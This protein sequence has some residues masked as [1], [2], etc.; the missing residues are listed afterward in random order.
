MLLALLAALGASL[1][2][3]GATVV[4]PS[5]AASGTTDIFSATCGPSHIAADDPIVFPGLPGA[6]HLHEFSG[7]W[8]TN[9]FSTAQ[10]LR[11]SRTTCD[12]ADDTAAYWMPVL[13]MRGDRVPPISTTAYFA[14]GRKDNA[15]IKAWPQGFRMIADLKNDTPE[16]TGYDHAGWLCSSGLVNNGYESSL[17]DIKYHCPNGLQARVIFPDC[18]DGVN[19][20][21]VA[22]DG[23]AAINPVTK[24]PYPNDHRSHVVYA[25]ASGDCPKEHPVATPRVDYKVLYRTKGLVDGAAHRPASFNSGGRAKYDA[26]SALE[27][28]RSSDFTIAGGGMEG[29]AIGKT[30]PIG[31][32]HADFYN[33]W[34]PDKLESLID[35]CIRQK[36]AIS[37]TR[38]CLNPNNDAIADASPNP[39]FPNATPPGAVPKRRPAAPRIHVS[40]KGGQPTARVVISA[41]LGS[42]PCNGTVTFAVRIGNR[43]LRRAVNIVKRTC[44]ART[45]V[46]TKAARGTPVRVSARFD[47]NARLSPR[48]SDTVITRIPRAR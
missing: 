11:A 10:S 22:P 43:D 15:S 4:A 28:N 18:W 29:T 24:Q 25:P 13:Y 40:V 9:A 2:A 38:P 23:T 14:P 26:P 41:R 46:A 16:R 37:D 27:G 47:G 1:I 36:L 30:Y 6:S 42:K 45:S 39:N 21:T 31:T 17:T 8:S 12:P 35:Y 7:A 32:F 20:D 44:T 33:G 3:R 34:K 48:R 19:L 5:S